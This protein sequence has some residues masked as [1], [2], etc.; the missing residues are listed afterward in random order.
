MRKH[1][2]KKIKAQKSSEDK[3][4]DIEQRTSWKAVI[5]GAKK[6]NIAMVLLGLL[7]LIIVLLA[8]PYLPD[9]VPAHY[10]ASG[11]LDRWSSKYEELILPLLML[12][13]C[14]CWLF[15][16]IPLERSAHKKSNSE[17]N[18]QTTIRV[19][20]IGGCCMFAVSTIMTI[21]EIA[22]C[23]SRG[24]TA[25]NIPLNPIVNVA[26]GFVFIVIGNVLPNTKP[27]RWSGMRMRGAFKSRES[28]RRCQ[29]FGG[30]EFII[31]GVALILIGI[32]AHSSHFIELFAVLAVGLVIVA[33]FA[34]YS[35]YAG[36]KYGDV[37][38][39]INKK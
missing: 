30:L 29:R 25:S 8:L 13:I 2:D 10:N 14:V 37:G 16:E 24:G 28:W 32:V 15:G 12:L 26:T 20:A 18:P 19:W 1:R 27:N 3:S 38:G 11:E 7:P 23:F 17:M 22:D 5:A 33:V 6:Q 34:V 35:S 21:W 9:I 31:G 4:T 36:K 39:T